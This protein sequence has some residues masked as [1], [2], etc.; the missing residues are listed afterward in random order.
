AATKQRAL[1]I[2]LKSASQ[3]GPLN[4]DHA[5]LLAT[6]PRMA[7]TQPLERLADATIKMRDQQ[8]KQLGSAVETAASDLASQVMHTMTTQPASVLEFAKHGYGVA[9]KNLEFRSPDWRETRTRR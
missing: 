7:V 5:K 8:L 1:E 2:Y 3:A 6:I 9:I 4:L